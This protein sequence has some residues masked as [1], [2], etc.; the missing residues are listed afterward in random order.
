[1]KKNSFFRFKNLIKQPNLV[2]GIFDK[3]FGNVSLKYNTK[4][5]IL[6]NKKRIA[7]VLKVNWENIHSL[8]QVHGSEIKVLRNKKARLAEDEGDGLV[9]NQSNVFL[10]IKT[11]DCF[12]VIFFDPV[13][14]VA[15]VVHVGWRGA[16]GK[17]F[18][19]CLLKMVSYFGCS[20]K[21]ILVGIGPGIGPCCFKHKNLI[22]EELPEWKAYIKKGKNKLF[23]LDIRNFLYDQLQASGI[24][25]H[26][27]EI[28]DACTSCQRHFFSHF[29]SLRDSEQEGR[30]ATI[31]GL[32]N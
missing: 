13:K 30:F 10:M 8:K 4:K 26:N 1:M 23:S 22:Q 7:E 25:K 6:A 14:K 12:P 27:I 19:T 9:T 15:A 17:L 16:I 2:H 11:A 31:I 21:D 20:P 29:R 24:L 18:L 3:S 32:R 5:E 28:M